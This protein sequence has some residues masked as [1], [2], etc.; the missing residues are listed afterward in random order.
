MI[1]YGLLLIAWLLTNM[2][3]SAQATTTR[4][5]YDEKWQAELEQLTQQLG[6]RTPTLKEGDYEV[7][8]WNRQSLV[9]GPAH[10]VYRIRKTNRRLVIDRYGIRYTPEGT[11]KAERA[12]P[13]ARMSM[14]TWNKLVDSQLLTLPTW[15]DVQ[16]SYYASFPKDS[17]WTEVS[18]DG[19]ITV[20]AYKFRSRAIFGDGESY[21]FSIFSHNNSRIYMYDNPFSSYRVL[22]DIPELRD[23]TGILTELNQLFRR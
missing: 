13:K 9:R 11:P 21:A 8:V 19:T 3:V 12:R 10:S 17:T 15:S 4:N 22:P 7:Y 1:R 23:V 18:P 20:K 16:T 6:W 2:P 5:W 14:E